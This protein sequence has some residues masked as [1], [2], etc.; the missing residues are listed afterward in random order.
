MAKKQAT[1][2]NPNTALIQGAGV[3]YKN[4]DNVPGV[5]AGLDKV[6]EG[7]MDLAEDQMAELEKQ[8]LK[9]QEITDRVDA[10]KQKI[11]EA[12]GSLSETDH[13]HAVKFMEGLGTRYEKASKNKDTEELAKITTE[14]NLSLIHI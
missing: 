12:G 6:V 3:A 14:Y 8:E 1:N 9:E 11:Q 5:Y 4:W 13:S 10:M 7:G 2:Y